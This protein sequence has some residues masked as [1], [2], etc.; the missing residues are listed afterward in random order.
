MRFR[1]LLKELFS[2]ISAVCAYIDS[3]LQLFI[4][5]SLIAWMPSYLHRHHAVPPGK[6]VVTATIFSLVTVVGM[7]V[8]GIVADRV[9]R[10]FSAR[11]WSAAI[12]YC[13]ASLGPLLIAFRLPTGT[14]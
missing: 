6:A 9:I 1:T 13:L 11:K 3:G 4:S 14:P 8:C 2:S 12:A 10:D 5:A 7:I